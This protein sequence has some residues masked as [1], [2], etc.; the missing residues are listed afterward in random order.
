MPVVARKCWLE[1]LRTTV[2]WSFVLLMEHPHQRRLVHLHHPP[3][4]RPRRSR[5]RSPRRMT[6][7]TRPIAMSECSCTYTPL[8]ARLA[9]KRCFKTYMLISK[10]LTVVS[11][12]FVSCL[13]QWLGRRGET[14]RLYLEKSKGLSVC[15]GFALW[16]FHL[17][18]LS[19][20]FA[21]HFPTD[22]LKLK[23]GFVIPCYVI[24]SAVEKASGREA[25][26]LRHETEASGFRPQSTQ[27][28]LDCSSQV[29]R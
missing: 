27:H 18:F 24:E 16:S 19:I 13:E 6:S 1:V 28:S 3:H 2:L 4:P 12:K 5:R 25:G 14:R 21:T 8:K 23:F 17:S 10:K 22:H 26:A 7:L 9:V 29:S 20:W 15:G 11:Q